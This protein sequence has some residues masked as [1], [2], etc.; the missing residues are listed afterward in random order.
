LIN[1][2]QGNKVFKHA[3]KS[4]AL[5]CERVLKRNNIDIS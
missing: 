3:V 2:M 4:M 5:V 1:K